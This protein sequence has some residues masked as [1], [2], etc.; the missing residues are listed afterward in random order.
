MLP[1]RSPVATVFSRD[2]YL[3]VACRL[4]EQKTPEWP[5]PPEDIAVLKCDAHMASSLAQTRA[6]KKPQLPDSSRNTHSFPPWEYRHQTDSLRE[7]LKEMDEHV[8][9]L[10]DMLKC[11]RAKSTR[12]QLR[13]NQLEAELR[14]RE[15]QSNRMKERLAHLPDRNKDKGPS[16]EVLNFPPGGRGKNVKSIKSSQSTAKQEE[17]ALRLMLERRE[18]E[19][20]EAMKLRH[21]LTTLLHAIRVDME[22]TLSNAEEDVSGSPNRNKRLT[23]AEAVLGDH[24]TGGV[25]Q[26][27]KRVQ[28]RLV[29]LQRE[30][31]MGDGTDH[32]KLLAQLEKEL[33]ESQQ[34]VKLQQQMLQD[35]LESS[36][37]SELSNSY[38]LEE[39]EHLQV[40]WADFNHQKRTF[41]SERQSFTEA[42]IRLSRERQNFENQK[43]SLLKQQYLHDSPLC[44]GRE[45]SNISLGP[46]SK[47]GCVP[48]S[49]SSIESSPV[50]VS[51]FH[52]G[53]VSVLT[54][55]TPELYAALSLS[56][57]HRTKK[58]AN[59]LERWDSKTDEIRANPAPPLDQSF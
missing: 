16:I 10:Q 46:A 5:H 56:Y 19:L 25:V 17:A 50:T 21:S 47:Y 4:V 12:L 53:R 55:S 9:R 32:D 34:I 11:E 59:Q 3:V 22:Q 42:A 45:A 26:S 14:R 24:V 27:W 49:P 35:S 52:Q 7:Q 33:K 38:F 43:G 58:G 31:H 30:G 57:N 40:H 28:Q 15:H 1:S 44:S 18:A 29:D 41:E 8:A 23:Q 54:P 37:P 2:S 20:R 39:W 36:I 51:G 13:V 48:I 6:E